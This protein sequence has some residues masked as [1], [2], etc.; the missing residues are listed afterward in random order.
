[1]AIILEDVVPFGRSLDEYR[2]MF[3]LSDADLTR[4]ILGV[5]DGP[6]SFNAEATSLGANIIS[7]DPIYE[8]SG[9]EISQRFEAVVDN[10][11]Q[12]VEATPE[13]W[14]WTYHGSPAGLRRNREQ[15]LQRFLADYTP[16]SERYQ[17]GSLPTLD[18]PAGTFDLALCS[19]FLFLYSAFYDYAFHHNAVW[20]MLRVSREVRIFPLLTLLL[21]RSP[22]LDPLIAEL[23]IAGY[24]AAVVEV[25]YGLQRG[26]NQMLR[27]RHNRDERHQSKNSATFMTSVH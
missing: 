25:D 18:F 16:N 11:I 8:L 21:E 2:C 14:V 6:A 19:H 9:A 4:T 3:K 15:A 24:D 1:M 17:I 5:G 23:Q 20:E 27:I 22:H 10:I 13:D 12:Q 7:V 26:G